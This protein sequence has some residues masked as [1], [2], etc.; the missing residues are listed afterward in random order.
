MMR[1]L[2]A[3]DFTAA[4]FIDGRNAR[5]DVHRR[6]Y[7]K[8]TKCPEKAGHRCKKH[9]CLISKAPCDPVAEHLKRKDGK[10]S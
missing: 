1:K 4:E 5:T 3:P 2:K 8:Y 10:Q 9:A 6:S 7:C